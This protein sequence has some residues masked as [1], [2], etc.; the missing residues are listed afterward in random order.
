M[1]VEHTFVTTLDAPDALRR[2]SRLLE[3]HGFKAEEPSA[4]EPSSSGPRDLKL[5]R[6][7]RKPARARSIVQLPQEIRLQWDRGRITVAMSIVPRDAVL[8]NLKGGP[9]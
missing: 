2:A 3:D 4:F 7:Q 8:S 9:L 5:Q 6:G 1:I